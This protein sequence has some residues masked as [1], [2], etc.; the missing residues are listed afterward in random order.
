MRS[1]LRSR[2]SARTASVEGLGIALDILASISD[3]KDL[4]RELIARAKSR[5]AI[6]IQRHWRQRES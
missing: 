2:Q 3:E 1:M 4:P 5:C 6:R